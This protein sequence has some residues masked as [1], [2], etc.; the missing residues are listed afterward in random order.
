MALT[1]SLAFALPLLA[2]LGAASS[3]D[4]LPPIG[5]HDNT[6]AAGNDR[7]GVREVTFE[8]RRGLMLPSGPDRPGTPMMAF[9]EPGKPLQLPGPM[10]RVAAGTRLAITVRNA[11]DSTIV[12]HGL[13]ADPADSLVLAPG[14]TGT[15]RSSAD[16]PGT[17]FYYGTFPG[18]TLLDRR[19]EDGHLAGAIVVDAPGP[20]P[21]DKVFVITISYHSRDSL[22]VLNNNRE[23]LAINGRPWPF[24]QRLQGTVGDSAHYRV[25]N[26]S[27][28]FHPMHLHGTFFRVAARGGA[29]RDTVLGPGGEHVVATEQLTPGATMRMAWMPD[30]PG[31]W[32]FH[33]HLTF[34]VAPTI[35]FG[36]DS[37]SDREYGRML[38]HDHGVDPDHHVERGMGGLLMTIT[39]PPPPGW[40]PPMVRRK[41]ITLEIPRDSMAGD[42]LPVFA[43]T[44]TAAADVTRPAARGG[45]GGMLLL[46]QGEPT[47]VRVVNHSAEP[48]AIHWHGMELENMYDGVVGLGGAPG[49]PVRA[50]PAG[51]SFDALMTPPRAGTFIYHTHLMELRQ[52]ESGLYGAMIV[53]PAGAAWDAAHDHVFIVGTLYKHGV[54]LNGA[55]VAPPLD[56][57][58]GTTHRLRLINITTGAPNARF[59]LVR[60][61]SSLVMWT[62]QAKDAIDLQ[63]SRR[64]T[65]PAEQVVSMGETYD[66][67]F[68]PP[69]AGEYWLEVRSAADV[70]LARQ[71][72]RVMTE[73]HR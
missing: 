42:L 19:V 23:L 61:D 45:P 7:N 24:T 63:P 2:L 10:I 49:Q 53:L 50:I 46:H 30:R 41:L 58:A 11:S 52:I 35:G 15:V 28:G 62:R 14:A 38:Y 6:V 32:L 40:S 64:V 12:L 44:L 29:W 34:H 25:I 31:T 43:P 66:M 26:A 70:L 17:R 73:G 13:S 20:R 55:K 72:L 21:P 22:G 56:L 57:E 65:V 59:Q 3:R 36:A 5:Y 68:A 39:V 48:T 60:A 67:L 37:M 8:I 54:V 51:G 18:R 9:A 1:R 71:L 33:C 4:V 27:R 69:G 16:R 47:T